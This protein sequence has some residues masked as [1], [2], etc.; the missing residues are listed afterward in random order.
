MFYCCPLPQGDQC[1]FFLW[2]D[3]ADGKA[4]DQGRTLATPPQTPSRVK[5]ATVMSAPP[6]ATSGDSE[7][8]IDWSQV[9]TQKLEQE[10]IASTPGS[11][12]A[13]QPTPHVTPFQSRLLSVASEGLKRKRE[14][15]DTPR[16]APEVS[17]VYV[18]S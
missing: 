12:Q 9:D 7:D 8:D 10:A 3:E 1:K 4:K 6:A 13:S 18:R 5:P 17:L 14:D 2:E 11:S 15:D 16:K